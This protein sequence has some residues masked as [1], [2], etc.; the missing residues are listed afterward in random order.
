M[1]DSC[2]TFSYTYI[3]SFMPSGFFYMLIG[4]HS[5]NPELVCP[6]SRM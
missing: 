1:P 4:L 6:D 2:F 3:Y 5:D